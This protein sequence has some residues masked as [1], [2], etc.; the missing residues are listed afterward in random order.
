MPT[1]VG[2][3]GILLLS[4]YSIE[5]ELWL[6]V[7]NT[8]NAFRRSLCVTPSCVP[9]ARS[10]NAFSSSELRSSSTPYGV[11]KEVL[12]ALSP[13]CAFGLQGITHI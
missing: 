13:S 10:R 4:E 6:N 11:E 2:K 8:R 9:L 5:R 1:F 3:A 12:S 7:I